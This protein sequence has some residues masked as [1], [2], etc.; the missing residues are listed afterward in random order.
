MKI[1]WL[2]LVIFT[3]KSYAQTELFELKLSEAEQKALQASNRLKS[4]A[5]EEEA[6]KEQ[7]NAQFAGLFPKLS[8]QGGYQYYGTI[9]N[10]SLGNGPAFPFGTN[11]T[12]SVGPQLNYTLWDSFSG[13][14]SYKAASLL[15]S[16]RTEDRKN[17]Q[18]QLLFSLRAAYVQVQLG[19]E[20]LRLIQDSL[21]LANA[22]DRDVATR[23]SAGAAAKLD[24]VT[25]GRSVLS[26]QIQFEQRQA[27]LSSAL[28][29]LLTLLGDNGGTN[30]SR[31]G[32]P[33]IAN[34]ALVVKLDDLD[35]SL[36][37]QDKQEIPDPTDQQPQI[38]SLDLQARSAEAAADSQSAKLL[39]TVQLSAGVSKIRPDIPNPPDYWQQTVGVTLSLP[40]Y[41][42]DPTPS[43]AAQQRNEAQAADYRKTQLREDIRRDF[44]KARN[45]LVS[46]RDQQ[47]LATKDV[48]QSELAARLYYSS[49]RAG[50]VNLIDV[51]NANLQALQSKVNAARI[52][53]QIL[54][55]LFLLKSL[56]GKE[57]QHG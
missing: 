17:A 32:P 3:V 41:L 13:R 34:V 36:S 7:S 55:Q 25:A 56:S 28:K 6:A 54:N 33:G 37:Q 24:V 30:V 57:P 8:L 51:Q 16:A 15:A 20:E 2:I 19:L 12:Y 10:I 5:A 40:L 38:Q 39:P 49:Y 42:G 52:D 44:T 22:Q 47:T 11:S 35:D 18:L 45:L 48:K 4:F 9:P 26:Y 53:A 23:F 31:P 43:L 1:L 27:E 46:L 14:K 29:D 21:Q 50:K